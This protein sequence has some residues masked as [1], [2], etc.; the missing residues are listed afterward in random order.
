MKTTSNITHKCT[1]CGNQLKRKDYKKL[2]VFFYLD[3]VIL[4][5]I[6]IFINA[7]LVAII[8]FVVT[9][10]IGTKFLMNKNRYIYI[11]KDCGAR[12]FG[13]ELEPKGQLKE[14]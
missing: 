2:A 9:I 12:Y 10:V 4:S 6:L 5:P 11:C 13:D 1:T 8:N 14:E 7:H 3:C